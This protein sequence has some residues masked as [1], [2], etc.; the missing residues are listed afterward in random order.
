M[1]RPTLQ[2]TV[3]WQQKIKP[4]F[5]RGLPA[6]YVAKFPNMPAP[7]TVNRYYKR[8][9][10]EIRKAE[11]QDIVE[12]QL[13]VKTRITSAVANQI[14]FLVRQENNMLLEES[15]LLDQAKASKQVAPDGQAYLTLKEARYS[16]KT[17]VAQVI[18]EGLVLLG[19]IETRVTIDEEVK[20]KVREWIADETHKASLR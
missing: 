7:K 19:E 9:V 17:K 8:W 3:Q 5:D 6:S 20:S 12:R 14:E 1:A 18:M 11:T 16:Q 13:E 2:Q 4:Y 10:D 15:A